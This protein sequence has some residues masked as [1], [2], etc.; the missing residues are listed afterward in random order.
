MTNFIDFFEPSA[1]IRD[2]KCRAVTH[3]Q[4]TFP[5]FVGSS[6]V[7]DK[8]VTALSAAFLAKAKRD[9]D[10]L[11]YSTRLYGQA[12]QIVHGRIH[13]GRKCGQDPL[14][15]T[16]IFQIYEVGMASHL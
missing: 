13:S 4:D 12:L 7:L 10:L 2:R 15:A 6:P 5:S 16:V 9:N 1:V 11:M 14:F 8:A 3:L